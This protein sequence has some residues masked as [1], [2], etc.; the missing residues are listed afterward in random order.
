[1]KKPSA[2]SSS[3]GRKAA[4]TELAIAALSFLAGEEERLARFLALTGL[5]PQS[6]RAAAREPGFLRGVLD[7]VAGDESLLL[8]FANE[9]GIDPVDVERARGALV[10][11]PGDTGAA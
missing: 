9:T 5:G 7:Y 8:A 11:R 4:A 2:A 3:E 1:M 6:L 10:E